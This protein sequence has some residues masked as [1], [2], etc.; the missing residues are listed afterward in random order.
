M[1]KTRKTLK[2]R[3][4]AKEFI[5]TWELVPGRGAWEPCQEKVLKLAEQAAKGNLVHAVS[6]TD[7]PGGH[8][9]IKPEVIGKE[10]A[11]MGLETI[12]HLTC[13]DKNRSQLES[14]LYALERLGLHNILV[15]TG[16]YVV[17]GSWGTP[18]PVFDLDSTQL[19]QLITAMKRGLE[20]PSSKQTVFQPANF[21]VGAVVSPFKATEAEVKLQY[22][23]LRKK[24]ANGAEFIVSQVG[25]D[26]RK[27]HELLLV[28]R[29]NNWQIP[30]FGNIF[31][32]T[33]QA[34]KLMNQ[35]K[36]PGCVVTDK[37][38]AEV[39][40]E[41]ASA[42]KGAQKRLERAAKLYAVLKR[43]GY[44]GV[45]IGGL[46]VAYEQVAY[47][48]NRGE[49]YLA[50]WQ[51]LIREFVY[52]QDQGYYLFA[53]DEKTGLNKEEMAPPPAKDD[54]KQELRYKISRRFHKLFFVPEKNLFPAMRSLSAK[55]EGTRLE[56]GFHALEHSLKAALYNCQDCG[57]CAL[58]DTAYVCPMGDCPKNQRNGPCGGSYYGW[59]EVYPGQKKCI[60]VRAF[61]NLKKYREEENLNSYQVNPCNWKL[62]NTSSWLNF[63]LGK[64]HSAERLKISHPKKKGD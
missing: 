25:Y 14:Q 56:K 40:L 7:N 36:F 58:I 34:A 29:Q 51:E 49:E 39:E 41:R 44:Q 50:N 24:I 35:Q 18:K 57:D 30:L 47:I 46:D 9:G 20:A 13:K 5:V 45:H 42:D 37:L 27:Y 61:A 54:T 63:Y 21:C 3:L 1:G 64:D 53:P 26:A 12:I 15:L 55:I 10:I 31:L 62:K 38:L 8:I 33:Y 16:D 4:Q 52:P 59:C 17:E 19:L 43:M 2:E 32:L 60:W 28:A 23:K 22:S 6:L 48:I 11:D